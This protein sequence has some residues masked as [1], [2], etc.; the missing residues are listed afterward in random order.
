MPRKK[1]TK[2]TKIT[3][4]PS[5]ERSRRTVGA[6]LEAT[7]QVLVEYGYAGTTTNH[8]AK[9]A[10]VSIASFYEYFENKDAAIGALAERMVE[11]GM[12]LGVQYGNEILGLEPLEALR[13][14][15]HKVVDLASAN[16]PLVRTFYQQVPF[17]WQLPRVRGIVSQ[18]VDLG[19][20]YAFQQKFVP[21]EEV[22]KN[23]LYLSTVIAGAAITQIATDPTVRDRRDALVNELIE[24]FSH[25]YRGIMEKHEG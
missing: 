23:R 9:R 12:K 17:V 18:I 3:R 2:R 14:L 25:Y 11:E 16:A 4:E 19:M 6:I 20:S 5:Q 1:S 24:M 8:I 15:L 13:V 10:G 22:T 21:A 7:A